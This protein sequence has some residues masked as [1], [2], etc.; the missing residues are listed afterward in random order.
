MQSGPDISTIKGYL[1][2]WAQEL[3]L[4]NIISTKKVSTV[5]AMKGARRSHVS[6]NWLWQAV[7]CRSKF[8]VTAVADVPAVIT[9]SAVSDV[10]AVPDVIVL[11]VPYLT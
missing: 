4:K 5:I 1:L 11:T 3:S 9:V 7:T 2:V 8:T 10:T 6:R